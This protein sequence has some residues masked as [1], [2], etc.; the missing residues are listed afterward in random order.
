[1][2]IRRTAT[3]GDKVAVLQRAALQDRRLS[4]RARGVLVAILSRPMNWQTSSERLARE[5]PREGRDAIRTAL[6]ELTDTGYLTRT[7][8]RREDGRWEWVWDLSDTPGNPQV[9]DITAGGTTTDE[10]TT[11]E[12]TTVEPSSLQG[13][14]TGSSAAA[15]SVPPADAVDAEELDLGVG[16]AAGPSPVQ[17]LVGAYAD[18]YKTGGGVPTKARLGACGKNVKR[19]IEQDGI[20]LPVLLAAVEAAGRARSMDL[21]RYLGGAQRAYGRRE[22]RSAM[23][24]RWGE[25]AH[26]M[27]THSG[28]ALLAIGDGR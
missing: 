26:H 21:D 15:S 28:G 22:E 17:V 13:D 7:R 9:S 24:D 6:T 23:F 20:D 11:V 18:A 8:V 5:T 10:P 25:I 27:D 16:P 12:P 19:L 4:F 14:S 1:M 2:S 3:A